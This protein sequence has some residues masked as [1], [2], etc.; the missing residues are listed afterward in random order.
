MPKDLIYDLCE[1]YVKPDMIVLK[2]LSKRGTAYILVGLPQKEFF[3]LVIVDKKSSLEAQVKGVLHE[4]FHLHGDFIAY[5]GGLTDKTLDVNEEI[6]AQIEYRAQE[7]YKAR[8]DIVTFIEEKLAEA[9]IV[10]EKRAEERARERGIGGQ[11]KG[12]T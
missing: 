4:V 3:G 2:N 6:E 7:T 12:K 1:R 5:T 9:K 8:P 10:L 11:Q